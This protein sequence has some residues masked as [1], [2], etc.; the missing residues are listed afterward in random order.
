MFIKACVF[1][2]LYGFIPT[3]GALSIVAIFLLFLLLYHIIY[4]HEFSFKV[5]VY[6][7]ILVVCLQPIKVDSQIFNV[8]AFKI[9]KRK[10]EFVELIS[11]LPALGESRA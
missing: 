8:I 1:L 7:W 6:V 11:V 2:S 9:V 10:H 4:F 3:E 5:Q